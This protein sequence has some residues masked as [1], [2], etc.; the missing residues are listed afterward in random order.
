MAVVG[1]SAHSS[2]ADEYIDTGEELAPG[3]YY[4]QVY[5]YSEGGSTQPYYLWFVLE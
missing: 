2:N 1:Y 4:I 3:R 5:H